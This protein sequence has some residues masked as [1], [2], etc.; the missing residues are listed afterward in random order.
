MV[1]KSGVQLIHCMAHVRRYAEKSLD[2]A[3][4]GSEHFL[5]EVQKQ[6]AIEMYFRENNLTGEEVLPE[7]KVYS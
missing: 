1:G 2:Y 3:K 7:S 6:Y 4:D 5:S